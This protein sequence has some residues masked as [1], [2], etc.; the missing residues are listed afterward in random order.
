MSVT[1]VTLATLKADIGARAVTVGITEAP[2][3]HVF[4]FRYG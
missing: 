1:V 2:V 4:R 3:T